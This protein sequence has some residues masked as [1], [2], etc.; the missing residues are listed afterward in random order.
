MPAKKRLGILTEIERDR[1]AKYGEIGTVDKKNLNFR[2]KKKLSIINEALGDINLLL[3]NLPEDLTK[4]YIDTKTALSALEA[5][6]RIM[7]LFDPLP[8]QRIAP[9]D[10]L[11]VR[12]ENIIDFSDSFGMAVLIYDPKPEEAGLWRAVQEHIT[13]L[14]KIYDVNNIDLNAYT[15]GEYKEMMTPLIERHQRGGITYT[16]KTNTGAIPS[17]VPHDRATELGYG[18][19]DLRLSEEEIEAQQKENAR[20]AQQTRERERRRKNQ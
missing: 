6:E 5:T 18:G 15:L 10:K 4:D 17:G 12:K 9:S 19:L 20:I 7:K 16:V 11:I 2:L 13:F 14:Q 1:L 3:N 8:I